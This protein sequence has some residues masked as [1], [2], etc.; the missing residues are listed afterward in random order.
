MFVK[1]IGQICINVYD[2]LSKYNIK[3]TEK[4]IYI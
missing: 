4:T 1:N 3:G 2:R